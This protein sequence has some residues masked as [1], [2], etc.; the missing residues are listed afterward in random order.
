MIDSPAD[1]GLTEIRVQSPSQQSLP[2][3][4]SSQTAHLHVTGTPLH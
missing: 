4:A 1:S 3:F 2:T